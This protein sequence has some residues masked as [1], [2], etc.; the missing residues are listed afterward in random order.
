MARDVLVHVLKVVRSE[1]GLFP[2]IIESFGG[3]DSK[4]DYTTKVVFQAVG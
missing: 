3:T 4:G 1:T 2:V